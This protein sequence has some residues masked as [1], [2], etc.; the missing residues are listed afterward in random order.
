MLTSSE[1]TYLPGDDNMCGQ[2]EQKQKQYFNKPELSRGLTRKV[3]RDEGDKR[4]E[5]LSDP[6]LG[7]GVD[8][9]VLRVLP[10]Q[11]E[12]TV[13]GFPLGFRAR[14]FLRGQVS[15]HPTVVPDV[16]EV[17]HQL[18]QKKGVNVQLYPCPTGED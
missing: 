15:P 13:P 17:L 6:T 5:F 16:T 9:K 11:H 18:D 14:P 2:I 12:Q 10:E 4:N 7:S 8:D 3:L 1:P